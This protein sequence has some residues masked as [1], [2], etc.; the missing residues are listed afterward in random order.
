MVILKKSH[1]YLAATAANSTVR[2]GPSGADAVTADRCAAGTP[3]GLLES[4]KPENV[5]YYQ[6]FGF[7]V[8]RDRSA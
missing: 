3:S 6:R 5:P 1:W 4:T 8:T 7:R 2:G